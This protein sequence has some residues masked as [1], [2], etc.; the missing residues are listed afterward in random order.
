MYATRWTELLKPTGS[1]DR[2]SQAGHAHQSAL[3]LGS[4]RKQ[5]VP[6]IEPAT[7][8]GKLVTPVVQTLGWGFSWSSTEMLL[9]L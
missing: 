5:N 8:T 7:Q 2:W 1:S 3:D 9:I 6:S 4:C